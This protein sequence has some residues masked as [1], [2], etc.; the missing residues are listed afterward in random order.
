MKKL[1]FERLEIYTDISHTECIVQDVRKDFANIIYQG[2][3]GMEAHALAHKI[4]ENE[5]E[6]EYTDEEV[7]LIR[8]FV[9]RGTPA[10]IDAINYAL[11][12]DS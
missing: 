4:Y 3:S 10:F 12:A 1:N 9:E 5:G 7:S 6:V 11:S 8:K 2:G